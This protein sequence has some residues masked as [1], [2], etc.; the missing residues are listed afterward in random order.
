MLLAPVV[1]PAQRVIVTEFMADPTPSRGLPLT[2]FIELYNSGTAPVALQDIA[3]ASGGRA[4]SAGAEDVLEPG[5]FLVLVPIDSLESWRRLNV[6]VVGMA[7][8]GLTNTADV[9]TLLVAGDTVADIHYTKGWY[10]DPDR[11]DGGYSLE[12]NGL[13]PPDCA[14]SW[15]AS[16]ADGGG[17][18][19]LRNSLDGL[20]LDSSPPALRTVNLDSSGFTVVFD[21]PLSGNLAEIFLLDG[22]V[23]RPT[24]Q[25][26]M[27]FVFELSMDKGLIYKLSIVPNYSD[28]SGNFPVDTLGADLFAPLPIRS[29]DLLINELLFDPVPGGGDFVELLNHSEQVISLRGLQVANTFTGV[30]KTVTANHFLGPQELVVLTSDRH[31][32]VSYFPAARS[33]AIVETELPALANERGNLTLVATDGTEVDA[34]DYHEDYHDALLNPLEGVSLERLDPDAPTQDPANWYSA[35]STVGFGTPTRPNSQLGDWE[36]TTF[37][38]E[39]E[40]FSPFTAGTNELL[41][42]RYRTVRPGVQAT[43]RVFDVAGHPVRSLERIALLARQGSIFWDGRDDSGKPMPVGPYILLVETFSAAGPGE[44]IKLVAVLAG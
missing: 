31:H 36:E 34:F 30:T 21:E 43:V 13:G 5:D 23:I 28:C 6:P 22:A 11:D 9:I 18:P 4:A 32:V 40:S 27:E 1:L 16:R 37:F 20:L 3:I 33:E 24:W 14:G 12:Y 19:G 41:E 35:S 10:G 17:T 44:R 42:V 39:T 38:L 2:E 7:L 29:G 25:T 26:N 8:P 15:S